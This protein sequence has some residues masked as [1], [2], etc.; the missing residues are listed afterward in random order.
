[1]LECLGIDQYLVGLGQGMGNGRNQVDDDLVVGY[2]GQG[3]LDGVVYS[4]AVLDGNPMYM[5]LVVG[6]FELEVGELLGVDG[7]ID[8]NVLLQVEIQ[9]QGEGGSTVY[10]HKGRVIEVEGVALEFVI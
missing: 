1:M 6:E 5:G 10:G 2:L 4:L 8:I 3:L 7:Y 9:E